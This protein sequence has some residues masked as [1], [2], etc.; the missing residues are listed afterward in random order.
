MS[1]LRLEYESLIET[2]TLSSHGYIQKCYVMNRISNDISEIL[3]HK[4]L[5]GNKSL[6]NVGYSYYFNC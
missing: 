6:I 3:F 2:E 1:Y 5:G 4:M